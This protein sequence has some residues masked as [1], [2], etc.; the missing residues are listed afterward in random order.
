M[1]IG[2][3]TATNGGSS[4]GYALTNMRYVMDVCY[5]MDVRLCDGC[6]V[7]LCFLVSNVMYGDRTCYGKQRSLG[8]TRRTLEAQPPALP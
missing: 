5:V 3:T 7:R 8:V 6:N 4:C 1:A 2:Y